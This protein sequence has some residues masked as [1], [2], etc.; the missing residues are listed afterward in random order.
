MT[1]HENRSLPL[2]ALNNLMIRLSGHPWP[3]SQ[4][5]HSVHLSHSRACSAFRW[6]TIERRTCSP[7]KHLTLRRCP[8]YST[9]IASSSGGR[10]AVSYACVIVDAV[11][12]LVMSDMA[13]FYHRPDHTDHADN[14]WHSESP[15]DRAVQGCQHGK[16]ILC[17][18]A[19]CRCPF[20]K[21]WHCRSKGIQRAHLISV[22]C[23]LGAEF[24]V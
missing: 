15:A 18:L 17:P 11:H 5:K 23:G 21:S 24:R 1:V 13:Q 10:C 9:V 19:A 22:R 8:S 7:Q 20:V 2:P 16:A 4:T 6:G 3:R 12:A 14:Q